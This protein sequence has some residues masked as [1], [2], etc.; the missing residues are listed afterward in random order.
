MLKIQ[1]MNWKKIGPL[2]I[3]AFFALKT[4]VFAHTVNYALE[5]KPTSDVFSYY[6]KLGF[7]HIIPLG[8]DHILFVVGLYLLSPKLKN[9]I[10]Q[11]TAFTVAHTITLIMSMKNIIVAPPDIVE[12]IIAL[13][14]VFIAVE[15]LIT[16]TLQP[17]RIALVFAFG[18]VHGMGFAS[19]LNELGI[20]RDAFFSSLLSFN[21]GVEFGQ[22]SVI[23]LCYALFGRWFSERE[24]YK[25]RVVVPMSLAIAAIAVFW[26]VQ[27]IWF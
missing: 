6:V 10:W 15:N 7:E 9:I 23:L 13:S 16:S 19:A 8:L 21:V 11:A 5:G 12:P 1:T 25:S 14:I 26:T 22:I 20:P 18:L 3:I 2:S 24:W 27:R 17:W 4:P